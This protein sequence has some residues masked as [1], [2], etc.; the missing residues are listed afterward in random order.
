MD[1]IY[2]LMDSKVY[3]IGK[4]VLKNLSRLI[5]QSLQNFEN[6]IVKDASLDNK[7]AILSIF[8]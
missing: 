2:Y 8:Q 3:L 7:G 5:N 1:N 4:I 6:I